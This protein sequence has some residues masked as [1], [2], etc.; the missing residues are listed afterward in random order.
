[1]VADRI[2]LAFGLRPDLR[3][4]VPAPLYHSAPNAHALF[5]ASAGCDLT[6]MPRFTPRDFLATVQAHRI[7]HSQ[8]VPTMFARLLQ[9]SERERRSYEVSSLVAVVHAAAPCPPEV[10]R[11]MID[12]WGPIILEYYGGTETGCV[13]GCDSEEWLAPPRHGRACAAGM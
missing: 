11:R 3:S 9:L 6:I 4:L 8:M 2:F 13:V 1:M 5:A 12:W 7:Q 10:K